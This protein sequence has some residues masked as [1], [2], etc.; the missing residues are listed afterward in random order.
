VSDTV[1][2]IVHCAVYQDGRR[3]PDP[4]PFDQ[5]LEATREP[6]AFVW[7]SLHEPTPDE[8]EAVH[9]EFELHEL[10]V[11][12][13]LIAHQRPKLEEYGDSLFVVL[14]TARY[15]DPE[16]VVDFGELQLFVGSGF[17]VTVEHGPGC[18]MEQVR[19]D[20][21]ERPG[22]LQLGPAAVMHAIVD[23]VIDE[24]APVIEGV[25]NDIQE[26]EEEVFSSR[27]LNPAERIYKLKRE[28]LEFHRAAAPLVEP[29]DRLARG[30][31]VLVPEPLRDYFR[32]VHD[33][34]LRVVEQTGGF[35]ELLTS[36]LEAN[37]T[38]VS[39]RQNEDM[40]KISAWVAIAAVP[41]VI[42]A[43]YG[44]NFRHMPELSW[45]LSYPAV[46][47]VIVVACVLLYRSFKRSGWL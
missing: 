12:D 13:A 4:L 43:I 6:G 21:E 42:G 33:H 39:V 30:R 14:K 34:L 31:V 40:R 5:S 7:I 38:Q 45:R 35:R 47:M 3:R 22:H 9:A 1:A 44:M 17:I 19:K 26:V 27:R 23:Q 16:E 11:E 28:V 29:L 18:D 25:D 37:L 10:A 41:T 32:D 8:F 46:V 15:V 36:V 20:V 2:V 24:Y